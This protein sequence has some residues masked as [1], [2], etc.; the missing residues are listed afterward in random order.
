MRHALLLDA[1]YFYAALAT[2]VTGSS[3]RAAVKVHESYMIQQLCRQAQLDSGGELLRV[4][5]Y[6]GAQGG[7]P[8]AHQQH[9]GHVD[10]VKLRMGRINQFGEQKGVDLRLGL[11]LV[12]MA[13][14]RA[15][16]TAYLVSGDDDLSEAVGE[17][18]DLGLK[19]KVLAVP[20]RDDPQRAFGVA[21]N[22]ALV[23]DGLMLM[24]RTAIDTGVT[25]RLVSDG[26]S[27][28]DESQ[29][30]EA[31]AG[32][33]DHAG[34]AAAT[35]AP[36]S[37]AQSSQ[38]VAAPHRPTPATIAAGRKQTPPP[39]EPR[40]PASVLA[41]SSDGGPGTSSTIPV[42]KI[43]EVAR[44]TARVWSDSA[45]EG[46]VAKLLRHKPDVPAD[47]DRLLLT[48]LANAC[49][50][51]DVPPWAREQL[52]QEFWDAIDGAIDSPAQA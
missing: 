39:P 52:R 44:L 50:V 49:G 30:P 43:E 8:D 2:H 12:S 14:N 13:V 31:V 1:G 46:G 29:N 3:N 45:G 22:L 41:Y 48:D 28:V 19:V 24:H 34:P 16:T 33:A 15:I 51:W 25:R 42:E 11:D 18:Q 9:I 47:I 27:G 10:G 37:P 21:N 35:A 23:S 17:A 38:P 4:L 5:W 20:D 7:V 40:A 6:D 32:S 36:D 26:A